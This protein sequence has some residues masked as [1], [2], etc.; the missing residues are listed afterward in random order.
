[1]KE[2]FRRISQGVR[3]E[4]SM[5]ESFASPKRNKT[6]LRLRSNQSAAI[7]SNLL[8]RRAKQ[9]EKLQKKQLK[10]QPS[11]KPSRAISPVA[12]KT[13]RGRKPK[14]GPNFPA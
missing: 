12:D 4:S 10:L 5:S 1:M 2:A 9:E 3:S 7:S 14:L 6:S 8:R 11:E 13:K